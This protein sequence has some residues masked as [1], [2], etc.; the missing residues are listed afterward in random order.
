MEP[1]V[2]RLRVYGGTPIPLSTACAVAEEVG[3]CTTFPSRGWYWDEN[4]EN[5]VADEQGCVVEVIGTLA[6]CV[7]ALQIIKR[8]FRAAGEQE[9]LYTIDPIPV[10]GYARLDISQEEVE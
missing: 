8:G 9:V 10:A 5:V 1:T 4:L 6:A 2:N 3:G 7:A